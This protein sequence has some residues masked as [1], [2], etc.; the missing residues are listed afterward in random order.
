MAMTIAGL[1]ESPK[2]VKYVFWVYVFWV[3]VTRHVC[4]LMPAAWALLLIH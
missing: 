4:Q 2:K 1:P 3:V